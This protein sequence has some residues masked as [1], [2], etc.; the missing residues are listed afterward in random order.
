MTVEDIIKQWL[1]ANGYDGLFTIEVDGCGCCI[2]DLA[3]CG[4]SPLDC[5]PAHRHGDELMW[6]EKEEKK[7]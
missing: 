6:P 4:E 1:K 3:P 5:M 7:P 2:D